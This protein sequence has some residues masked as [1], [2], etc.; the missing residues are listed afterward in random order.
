MVERRI[1]ESI[2]Y[3][4]RADWPVSIRVTALD[5]REKQGAEQEGKEKQKTQVV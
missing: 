4:R 3:P 1:D 5:K 2:T